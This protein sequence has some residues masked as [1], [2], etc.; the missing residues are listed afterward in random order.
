MCGKWQR[1]R[2]T[3]AIGNRTLVIQ[4]VTTH[5]AKI[6]DSNL[7]TYVFFL[8]G[9]CHRESEVGAK[10]WKTMRQPEIGEQSMYMLSGMFIITPRFNFIFKN[11][12]YMHFYLSNF[13]AFPNWFL[14]VLLRWIPMYTT[15]Q[16]RWKMDARIWTTVE[17]VHWGNL[18]LCRP[19]SDKAYSGTEN[20]RPR[21]FM[22]VMIWIFR[23]SFECFLEEQNL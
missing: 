3:A 7:V 9:R 14:S 20:R 8:L 6:T 10:K 1:E 5:F 13:Y 2:K 11:K 23:F 19:Q 22:W 4:S 12:L 15:T 18:P 16:Q 17:I 21:F